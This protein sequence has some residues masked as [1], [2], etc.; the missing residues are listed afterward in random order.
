M[1]NDTWLRT[2]DLKNYCNDITSLLND[3]TNRHNDPI[4]RQ[5][6]QQLQQFYINQLIQQQQQ[7]HY[8]QHHHHH[9][10]HQ[11]S[12]KAATWPMILQH[13]QLNL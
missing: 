6:Q 2:A 1:I 13:H 12:V 9:H 8:H 7:T 5:R 3:R 10:H 11:S 4:I